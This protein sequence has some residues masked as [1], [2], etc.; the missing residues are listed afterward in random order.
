MSEL[1]KSIGIELVKKQLIELPELLRANLNKAIE[2]DVE[3][4]ELQDKMKYYSMRVESEVAGETLPEADSEKAPKKAYPN[5]ALRTAEVAYRLKNNSEY[6]DWKNSVEQLELDYKLAGIT[7]E[8]LR[9]KFK[10]A[11]KL[12]DLYKP[13]EE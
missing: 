3:K 13:V 1:M 7:S 9:M 8:V 6:Q 11:I 10:A 4:Q 12:A 5:E 2:L